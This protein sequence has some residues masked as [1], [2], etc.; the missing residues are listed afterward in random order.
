MTFTTLTGWIAP[1]TLSAVQVLP[2]A[3]ASTSG[4]YTAVLPSATRSISETNVTLV[5]RAPAGLSTWTL[6]E[7]LDA[8][9][10][11]I[12]YSSGGIWSSAAHTLT[13]TGT[14]AT[15]NTLSYTVS[16]VTSGVYAV[17]GTVTP[18]PAN[19]PVTVT[20]DSRIIKANFRRIINGTKI[21]ITVNQPSSTVKWYVNE[22]LPDGEVL[23]PGNI[24]GPVLFSDSS[25]IDWYK[26]G[27]GTNLT[28]EVTGSPGT[29]TLS[30]EGE[31]GTGGWEP[32]FG[33]TVVTIPSANIPPPNIL[34]FT[35]VAG[36]NVCS[37]SF[38]SVVNQAY[39]ILT[40]AT[41]HTT[42]AWASCLS[43][44]GDS[45]VTLRTVPRNG[46]NLFYRVRVQQ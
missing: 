4:V 22:Y 5:V 23:T 24:T 20:G 2:G 30:G 44:T 19:V 46:A 35:P 11:P 28:Y 31:I 14:E 41:I 1:A 37:L 39:V 6:V 16:C 9:L 13:F 7:T 38:T 21:T 3:T 12:S 29:Y 15:T 32:I 25:E 10:T 26:K 33:D 43:V 42:N 8:G 40:N 36:T 17:S 45:G 34:S 18:Q 27:A